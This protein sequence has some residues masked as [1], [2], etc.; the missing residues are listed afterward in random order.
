LVRKS[1]EAVVFVALLLSG[2]LS[3][4]A[5]GAEAGHPVP[6]LSA[7]TGLLDV[8]DA[9]MARHPDYAAEAER[10]ERLREAERQAELQAKVAINESDE[11]IQRRIDALFAMSAYRFYFLKFRNVTPDLHRRILQALPYQAIRS[12]ADISR[13]LQELCLNLEAMRPWLA[14]VVSRIDLPRCRDQALPWLPEGKYGVP[15]VFFLYDGNGD[16]FAY[17]GV[18]IFDLFSLVLRKTPSDRRF[19]DLA[20]VDIQRIEPVL[21]HEFHHV[22]AAPL[23]RGRESKPPDWQGGVRQ[24]LAQRMV[25]EGV[26]MR[27]D[28]A[29]G[30]RREVMEDTTTVAYWIGQLNEKFAGLDSGELGEEEWQGWYGETYQDLARERLREFLARTRPAADLDSLACRHATARPSLVYTLGWWMISRIL[31]LPD[32]HVRVMNLLSAPSEVFTVYNEAVDGASPELLV[33]SP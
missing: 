5:L 2:T 12:P 19:A 24:F 16:A 6:D 29:P 26:A 11:E 18:V 17:L 15:E 22:F 3:S 32:G 30:V 13:N 10:L 7:V 33:T 28:L 27:C 4:P 9:I 1:V 31:D 23:R 25:S 21:A 20:G 8:F 14:D